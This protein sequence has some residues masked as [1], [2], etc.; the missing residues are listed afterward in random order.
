MSWVMSPRTGRNHVTLSL[1]SVPSICEM[2]LTI[3]VLTNFHLHQ[4]QKQVCFFPMT[5]MS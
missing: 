5:L 4:E 1:L 2:V 3:S